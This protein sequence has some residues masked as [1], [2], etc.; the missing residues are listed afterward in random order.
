MHLISDDEYIARL[1]TVKERMSTQG[2]DILLVS[3]PENIYY[4]TGYS[5]WSFYT[6]QGLVI[7]LSAAEPVLILR[8]MDTACAEF[9]AY[10]PSSSVVGYPEI[11]VGDPDRH[12]MEFVADRIRALAPANATVG[13]EMEAYFFSPKAYEVLKAGLPNSRLVDSNLLVNWTRTYKS[14]NELTIMRRSGEVAQAAM[15]VALQNAAVGMR[16]CDLAADIRYRQTA[17]TPAFGGAGWTVLIMPSGERAAAPHLLWTDARYER[18]TAINFELG[19]CV[20]SYHAG[21]SRTIFLGSPPDALVDLSKIVTEGIDLA[22]DAARPGRTCEEVF[23][24]WDGFIRRRGH[25]KSSRI[26]YSIGIGF[27]PVWIEHTASLQRG[28]RTELVPNMTFHMICGM[29][30]GT[31]NM[32]VSETLIIRDGAAEIL[33]TLP[34]EMVVK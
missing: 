7:T 23:E 31:Q 16:E 2:F 34:R 19:G 6:V 3:A 32:V 21:L 27:Q 5:G 4:L 11:Y 25:E 33:S 17:G 9:T 10:L 22:I 28:D 1:N 8:D 12:A 26:G 20:D 18:D 29:W 30:K 15:S 13:V 24:A 14:E